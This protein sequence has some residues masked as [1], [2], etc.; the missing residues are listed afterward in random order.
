MDFSLDG[1]QNVEYV[2]RVLTSLGTLPSLL[3]SLGLL[4]ELKCYSSSPTFT[5]ARPSLALLQ[6][7]H[8]VL[9]FFFLFLCA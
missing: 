4:D 2:D 9:F 3:L 6:A 8:A 1:T 5:H 7:A